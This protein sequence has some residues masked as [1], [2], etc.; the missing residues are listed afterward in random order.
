MKSKK[1]SVIEFATRMVVTRQWRDC[2]G[3]GMEKD[4]SMSTKL[5]LDR[6]KNF[7]CDIA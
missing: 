7:W 6:S 5:Q 4:W 3:E 2:G 1:G